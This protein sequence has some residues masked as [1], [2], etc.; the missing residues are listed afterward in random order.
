MVCFFF[1]SSEELRNNLSDGMALKL[2]L[3]QNQPA[4]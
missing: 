4:A 3:K 1:F 2:R